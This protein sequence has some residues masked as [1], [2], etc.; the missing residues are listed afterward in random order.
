MRPVAKKTEITMKRKVI[1]GLYKYA[2]YKYSMKTKKENHLKKW[3]K[4]KKRF[5]LYSLSNYASKCISMRQMKQQAHA[6]DILRI[7]RTCFFQL[8][9]NKLLSSYSREVIATSHLQIMHKF[10]IKWYD[11]YADYQ[12]QRPL[13]EL[14]N[15][16]Y[17]Q[18]Q[19]FKFIRSYR[20]FKTVNSA[21]R[22][23]HN[24]AKTY[25]ARNFKNS[26]LKSM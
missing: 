4:N 1:H 14:A 9:K 23:R 25:H 21:V 26:V 19:F 3:T 10:L 22:I 20:I 7:S 12:T 17:L 18:T 24:I 8:L 11:L 15:R 2:Y 13:I 16:H 5:A 6:F